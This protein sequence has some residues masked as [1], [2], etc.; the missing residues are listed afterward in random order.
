[1]I[2]L[3]NTQFAPAFWYNYSPHETSIFL[4]IRD[5]TYTCKAADIIIVVEVVQ[6]CFSI[7]IGLIILRRNLMVKIALRHKDI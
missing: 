5:H 7:T 6:V 2:K 1:M 3:L 4:I